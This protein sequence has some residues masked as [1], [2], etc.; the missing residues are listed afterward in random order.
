MNALLAPLR[1]LPPLKLS[2]Y[3]LGLAGVLISIAYVKG[4][5]PAW[6]ES[7]AL[8][9]EQHQLSR[10]VQRFD[11]DQLKREIAQLKRERETAREAIRK[12]IPDRSLQDDLP[13]ILESLHQAAKARGLRTQRIQPSE[14]EDGGDITT[15]ALQ[16]EVAGLYRD[17]YAWI[18]TFS[19]TLDGVSVTDIRATK[20]PDTNGNRTLSMSL[21]IYGR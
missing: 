3:L 6:E 10:Q 1:D 13:A 18:D 5:K 11:V 21:V 20:N 8:A 19:Q 15:V 7:S 16:I 2:A 12:I 14:A 9:H 17:L 4:L